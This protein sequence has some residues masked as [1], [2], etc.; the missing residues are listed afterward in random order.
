MRLSFNSLAGRLVAVKGRRENSACV[1]FSA[2][3]GESFRDWT[4][5]VT[6]RYIQLPKSYDIYFCQLSP[7]I[8]MFMLQNMLLKNYL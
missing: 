2:Q 3:G 7:I 1:P 6:V 8:L 4:T 5:V